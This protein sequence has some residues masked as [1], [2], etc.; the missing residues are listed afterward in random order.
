MTFSKKSDAHSALGLSR[1]EKFE[2]ILVYLPIV[3]ATVLGFVAAAIIGNI[4]T[5]LAGL[6]I[7]TFILGLR[8]GLDADHIA[9]IDNTTRKLMQDGKKRLT[10]GTWFSLGHSSRRS[11]C[12][13]GVCERVQTDCAFIGYRQPCCNSSFVIEGTEDR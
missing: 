13:A 7:V 3:I 12:K 5:V 9:A 6:G 11:D 2:I 4:S 10:V 1:G 8:H